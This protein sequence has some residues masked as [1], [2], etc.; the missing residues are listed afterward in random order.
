MKRLL[1]IALSAS[2]MMMGL[3]AYADEVIDTVPDV[4]VEEEENIGSNDAAFDSFSFD[5]TDPFD[6][7]YWTVKSL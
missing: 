1:A 3:P 2:L 6:L 7:S 5:T 4:C